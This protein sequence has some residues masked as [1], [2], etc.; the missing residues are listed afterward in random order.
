[1][2]RSLAETAAELCGCFEAKAANLSAEAKRDL[3][4]F[5]AGCRLTLFGAGPMDRAM[6][7]RGGVSL[8]EVDPATLSSK[9]IRGLYFAGEILDLAGPCGGY[10]M[11]WAFSSGFFAGESAARSLKSKAGKETI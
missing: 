3:V 5:L 1:M 4:R 8:K 7:M 6:A 10:N 2:P 9:K 11:Q